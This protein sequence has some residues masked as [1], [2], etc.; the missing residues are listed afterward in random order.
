MITTRALAGIIFAALW[1]AGMLLWSPT[2]DAGR[3]G[4][5]A[6]TGVITGLLMYWLF[7]KFSGHHRG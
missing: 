4:V 5:A 3:I 2:I 6:I 1:T 7:D